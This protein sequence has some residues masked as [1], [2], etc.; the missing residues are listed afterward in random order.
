MKR[1]SRI[2]TDFIAV[3]IALGLAVAPRAEGQSVTP[4]RMSV[5]VEPDILSYFIG[6]YS[7][8]VNLS[9]R[10]G[11]QVALGT[12]RYDVPEFL[13]KGD[14]NFAAAQWDATSTSIQ[15]LRMTYRLNGPM[16]NGPAVGGIVLNQNW[17]LRSKPLGGETKFSPLSA[18]VTGGYYQHFGKHFY[19]YPTVAFT[20]NTVQSGST[21]V[22]GVNYKDQKFGPNG[23]L[24]VGWEFAR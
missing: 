9:F 7:G 15:V 16:R 12:G 8:I 1:D 13:V 19:I 24:H 20:Y 6:G 22:K 4:P 21:A 2:R 11:L 3:L 5:A 18:G 23:S 14:P 10:N 17:R